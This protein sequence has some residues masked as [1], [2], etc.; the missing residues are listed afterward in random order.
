MEK[1]TLIALAI[2]FLVLGF[3]PVVLEK[4]YPNYNKKSVSQKSEVSAGQPAN[5]LADNMSVASSSALADTVG[6]ADNEDLKINTGKVSIGFNP[7]SGSIREVVFPEFSNPKTKKPLSFFSLKNSKGSPLFLT[8]NYKGVSDFQT[9]MSARQITSE[10]LHEG[11]KITKVLDWKGDHHANFKLRFENISGA[12]K[13]L[14]YKL[15][16]GPGV[17]ARNSIDAQYIESN[18]YDAAQ[19][20]IQHIRETKASKTIPSKA[21][22]QWAAIKDRHFS[23]ILKPK[24][25]ANF[26]GIHEGLG[27]HHFMADLVF[28]K[29]IVPAN[30]ISE[31]E[32]LVYIGPNRLEELSP[33]GLDAI[34]N[35]GK[36]D[37]IGKFLVGGLELANKIFKNYGIAIIALTILTNVLLFPFTRIS[38]MSMKR[39]QLIQPQM[40][41]LKEQHKNS[42][43]KLNKEMMELYKK[44]KVN[45][46]GGCLP[47]LLQMPI[48]I[49]LYVALSKAVILIN[50]KFLWI[51]DL[52]SPDRVP[53]PF[54]LPYIGS[55]FHAL[56]LIMCAGMAI[57]QK[58][59]AVKIEGQD[60]TMEQQ[61]KMMAV[62]MPII[63][64]FVFYSMPSGLVL[65][66]LTNTVIMTLYQ[67]S[68]KKVT[69]A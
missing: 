13:I 15:S 46:F 32:F 11:F 55:E 62:M 27:D 12:D 36:L 59:S 14:S 44:H 53:L 45:P 50:A 10:A 40:N 4:F 34:V 48:F 19:G 7:R 68:L 64:G 24:E 60:P 43:D 37:T 49:A 28:G 51:G 6:F 41:K 63:F 18:F 17:P 61:Q 23:L 54:T 9:V 8:V 29:T 39:M 5:H 33:L 31:Q 21:A 30:G 57:Q 2:S 47:M 69:L 66:W 35:F 58:L 22:P 65:Y 67:L 42:P 1:R 26:S 25:A 3:Y 38:Y 16:V 56:P 20:K 52:S